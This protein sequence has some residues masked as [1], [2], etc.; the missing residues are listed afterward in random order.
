MIIGELLNSSRKVIRPLVEEYNCEALMQIAMAQIEAGADYLDL[1]CGTF[2]KDEPERLK[3]LVENVGLPTGKPLCI[4]SPN[5]QA[6]KEVLPIINVPVLI[7]S[8]SAEKQRYDEILPLALEYKTKLVALCM[9]DA[10]IPQSADA[11]Y[12]IGARLVDSLTAAGMA[13]EDIYLDPLVQPISVSA[14]GARVI[15]DTVIRIKKAFPDIHCVCG[16]SNIS[17]GLPNRKLINRYFLAQAAAAGM[18]SFILDPTDKQLMGGYLVARALLGE[19]RFCSA[20]LKAHRK[21]LFDV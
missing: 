5:P 14:E 6:L 7:N 9:D 1:N 19:D 17:F 16:L 20:Y 4:D 18:D 10:E 21:G 2:R 12:D 15:L 3:W 13:Q 8:I 11:R